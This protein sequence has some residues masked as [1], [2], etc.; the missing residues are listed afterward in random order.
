MRSDSGIYY[1]SS[2]RGN[3]PEAEIAHL[4]KL[5]DR[6]EAKALKFRLGARMGYDDASTARDIALIP[7]VC[8]HFGDDMVL[9]ADAN[10]SYDVPLAIRIGRM[11]EDYCYGFYEEPVK[12][13]H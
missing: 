4:Q 3:S 1:A 7:L 9:C 11:L 5:A 10:S 6:A 13:D 2:N 8:R 12:F